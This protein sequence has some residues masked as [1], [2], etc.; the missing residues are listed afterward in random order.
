M[1]LDALP[2]AGLFR[3]QPEPIADERG[4][5]ARTFSRDQLAAAGLKTDFPE[6]SVSFNK[7]KGTLRGLHW[8]AA[9]HLETKIVTC[10]RGAIF[11]VAVDM[12]PG[13][14]TQGRWHALELSQENRLGFYIPD[15]FAHGFQTLSDDSEVMYHI[16]E[17]YRGGAAR[18]VRWSDPDLAIRWPAAESRIVSDRDRE[19]PPF[20]AARGML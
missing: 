14:P 3:L 2:L 18:G 10:V 4:F 7:A 9:P 5:F 16:S 11:D 8:Q 19:L 12:R 20:Q 17:P 15:G 13:S 1:I 6:W